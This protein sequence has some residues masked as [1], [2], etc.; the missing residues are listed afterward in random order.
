M[1]PFE[2]NAVFYSNSVRSTWPRGLLVTVTIPDSPPPPVF[3]PIDFLARSGDNTWG[4]VRHFMQLMVNEL[5][6]LRRQDGTPLLL[7]DEPTAIEC[8]FV[9]VGEFERGLHRIAT[10]CVVNGS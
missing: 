1:P 8:V 4:L 2:E 5:G 6:E 7:A 3:L 9:P 10:S